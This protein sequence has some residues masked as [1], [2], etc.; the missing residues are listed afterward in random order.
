MDP[1][2]R[3]RFTELIQFRKHEQ[4][5]LNHPDHAEAAASSHGATHQI[6]AEAAV[7]LPGR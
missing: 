7:L 5:P 2:I 1:V 4:L 6:S 3:S